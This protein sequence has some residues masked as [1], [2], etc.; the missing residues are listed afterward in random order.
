MTKEICETF[1]YLKIK[2]QTFKSKSW[3][4]D[5]KTKKITNFELI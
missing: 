2:Q 3:V 4:K 1:K 5:S